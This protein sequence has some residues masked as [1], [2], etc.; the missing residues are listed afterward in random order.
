[1]ITGLSSKS[2]NGFVPY[3]H[4]ITRILLPLPRVGG[5]CLPQTHKA[6]WCPKK[7]PAPELSPTQAQPVL[8]DCNAQPLLGNSW[9]LVSYRWGFLLT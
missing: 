9:A 5:C 2:G 7:L 8:N 6:G 1:M 3:T 4:K